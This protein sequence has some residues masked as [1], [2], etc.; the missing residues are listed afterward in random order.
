M[1]IVTRSDT[2][3]PRTRINHINGEL[4]R[5]VGQ[6]AKGGGEDSPRRGK[7]RGN[8]SS[9]H[10][11]LKL[12]AGSDIAVMWARKRECENCGC[13]RVGIVGRVGSR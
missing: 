9:S 5:A 8:L 12:F 7:K 6:R 13:L 11:S 4:S 3:L 2:S 10:L 1:S